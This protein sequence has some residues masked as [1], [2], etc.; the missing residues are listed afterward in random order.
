MTEAEW[1]TCEQL[2]PMLEFVVGGYLRRQLRG[3]LLGDRQRKLRLFLCAC[4]RAEGAGGYEPLVEVAERYAEGA[5]TR[6]E[7]KVSRKRALE[8]WLSWRPWWR[9]GLR[10]PYA[11]VAL[12]PWPLSS[13]VMH[14]LAAS[15]YISL[16]GLEPRSVRLFREVIQP[17]RR[18]GDRPGWLTRDVHDVALAIVREQAFE[19]M[20]VLADALEDAGCDD[21]LLLEHCRQGDKHVRGCWALDLLTGR[22]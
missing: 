22:G 13:A 5:A 9:Y 7:L 20:D 10:E 12:S 8:M 21:P 17:F 6:A 1:L 16:L 2:R 3:W 11:R 15:G 14:R 4:W 18:F 19:R